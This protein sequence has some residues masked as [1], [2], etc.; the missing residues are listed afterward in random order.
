MNPAYRNLKNAAVKL[1][2]AFGADCTVTSSIGAKNIK[3]KAVFAKQEKRDVGETYQEDATKTVYL[4]TTSF[5]PSVPTPGD[6]CKIG[7]VEYV[8]KFVEEVTPDGNNN[9]L[10][11]MEVGK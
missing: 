1:T 4:S 9:L 8:I 10:I 7:R 6:Y 11:K 2:T 3:G 5:N